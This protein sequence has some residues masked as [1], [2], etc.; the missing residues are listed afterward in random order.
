MD[1]TCNDYRTEMIL[2]GLR[3]RLASPDL[4]GLEREALRREI[5]KLEKEMDFFTDA[6]E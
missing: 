2:L 3:R 4:S 6:E 5:R 1:Y